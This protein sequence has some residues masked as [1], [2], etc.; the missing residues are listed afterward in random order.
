M[1]PWTRIR[2]GLDPNRCRDG[3]CQQIPIWVTL[4]LMQ[5]F[6]GGKQPDIT[7][8]EESVFAFTDNRL[9][10]VEPR[11][12][13]VPRQY[14]CEFFWLLLKLLLLLLASEEINASFMRIPVLWLPKKPSHLVD[15]RYRAVAIQSQS[16]IAIHLRFRGWSVLDRLDLAALSF[17]E[18]CFK[19]VDSLLEFIDQSPQMIKLPTKLSRFRTF[20]L[21]CGAT[22][23][24]ARDQDANDKDE[25]AAMQRGGLRTGQFVV[26]IRPASKPRQTPMADAYCPS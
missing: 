2:S 17:I 14:R 18:P 6:F 8:V 22:V 19:S 20:R 21:S 12:R 25:M 10:L 16:R 26:R 3:L 1:F 24:G 11:Y 4:E 7:A 5:G 23:H 15:Q 13:I 9:R